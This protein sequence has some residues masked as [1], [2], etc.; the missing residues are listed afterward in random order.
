MLVS[1][2]ERSLT[3]DTVSL[4]QRQ[5]EGMTGA[6]LE[7]RRGGDVLRRSLF[8][9]DAR[10]VSRLAMGPRA[11]TKIV[12]P[13]PFLR[14]PVRPDTVYVWQGRLMAGGSSVPAQSL[15]RVSGPE[16]VQTPAGTF[17]TYRVDSLISATRG[18]R[19][20]WQRTT[21]WFAPGVGLVRECYHQNGHL[22]TA[23]LQEY[24][25]E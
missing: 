4:G 18:R 3:V 22:V 2:G 25:I 8:V 15:S 6:L 21:T 14:Y 11:E 20:E 17:R 16:T 13:M 12:P 23:A 19:V 1:H 24:S 5:V 9:V 10:G 7:T